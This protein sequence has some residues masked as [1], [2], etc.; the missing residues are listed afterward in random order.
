MKFSE[1]IFEDAG[2]G[3][4]LAQVDIGN[5]EKL[6]FSRHHGILEAA[7]ILPDPDPYLERF[8]IEP[9]GYDLTEA[10]AQ[11]LLDRNLP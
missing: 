9:T 8:H 10:Q 6:S 4:E 11:E 1:L 5:G 2:D 3:V 7:Y